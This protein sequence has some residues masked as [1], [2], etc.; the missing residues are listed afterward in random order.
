MDEE[1]VIDRGNTT[2]MKLDADEQALM[3]EIEI[4]TARPQPVR[5]PTPQHARRPPQMEHQEAM[6]AFVNQT[7]KQPPNNL[8]NRKKKLTTVKMN[9]CFLT[10]PMMALECRKNNP[11]RDIAP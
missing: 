8:V 5:R 7:N 11:L 2:V 3:D 6:D 4:S 9:Q 1:I 10:M